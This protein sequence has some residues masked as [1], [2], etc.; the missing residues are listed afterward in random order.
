MHGE[1]IGQQPC[2]MIVESTLLEPSL[3]GLQVLV[4]LTHT[5]AVVIEIP[6]SFPQCSTSE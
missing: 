6:Q 3:E 1:G 5:A 2:E 4:L